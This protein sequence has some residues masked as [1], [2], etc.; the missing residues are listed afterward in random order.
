M[1]QAADGIVFP[2]VCY[3]WAGATDGFAGTVS[4]PPERV[5][6]LVPLIA[7][8][9]WK[10]G[11]RRFVVVSIHGKNEEPLTICVR[12]LY[13]TDGIVAQYLNP[14]RSAT[15]EAEAVFSGEWEEGKEVSM[16]L[17]SLDVLGCPHLYTEKEA[18]YDDPAPPHPIHQMGFK[19]ATG[20]F[21]Q[22]TRHHLAP[23]RF[24]SKDRGKS[25]YDLQVKGFLPGVLRLDE[26]YELTKKEKNQGWFR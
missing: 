16:L 20:F 9:A 6:E 11:F 8:R 15:P 1:A 14:Y 23:T 12:R 10:M 18:A 22:D 21:Y 2:D 19:G 17:A 25:Y 5:V 7:R 24:V 4:I 13:E 3:T 26:Y